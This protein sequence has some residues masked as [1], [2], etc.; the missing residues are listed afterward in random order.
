MCL[1]CRVSLKHLA[2]VLHLVASEELALQHMSQKRMDFMN[3]PLLQSA[4]RFHMRSVWAVACGSVAVAWKPHKWHDAIFA[5]VSRALLLKQKNSCSLRCLLFQGFFEILPEFPLQWN[6]HCQQ[7][8]IGPSTLIPSWAT[9]FVK[10]NTLWQCGKITNI[11]YIYIDNLI[12]NMK[13]VHFVI[14]T[15]GQPYIFIMPT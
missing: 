8:P 1:V 15:Y 5:L 9:F 6:F 2:K 4:G 12:Y 11:L 13:H 10:V 14:Y 3:D 7:N